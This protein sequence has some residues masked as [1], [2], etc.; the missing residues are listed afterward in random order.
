M[1]LHDR[2]FASVFPASSDV[3]APTPAA[4]PELGSSAFGEAFGS[5]A[6]PQVGFESVAAEQVKWD[7]A[8]HT[9][10]AF[11]TL[12][13]ERI[14]QHEE[15]SAFRKKWLKSCPPQTQR[16]LQYILSGRNQEYRLAQRDDNLLRWYYEDVLVTHYMK[17]V[18]PGL[19]KVFQ[20]KVL[21]R[22]IR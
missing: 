2:I 15:D 1:A 11:L 18:L 14:Y 22:A 9:A 16:V 19:I 20:M 5:P 8:W 7:R 3:E 17:H 6:Q 13:N 12:P 4:T 21:H 10:T